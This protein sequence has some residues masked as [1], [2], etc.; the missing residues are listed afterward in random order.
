MTEQKITLEV[1]THR[2]LEMKYNNKIY[3]H[4]LE[5]TRNKAPKADEQFFNE[6]I[7]TGNIEIGNKKEG[8]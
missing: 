4:T 2:T 1:V 7:R 5:L 3:C 8:E 6:F